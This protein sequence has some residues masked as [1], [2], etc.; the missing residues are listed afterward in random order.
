M[1]WGLLPEAPQSQVCPV[2]SQ[3]RHTVGR[4]HASVEGSARWSHSPVAAVSGVEWDGG[5]WVW[6]HRCGFKSRPDLCPWGPGEH[7]PLQP[8]SFGPRLGGGLLTWEATSWQHLVPC[9]LGLAFEASRRLSDSVTPLPGA[10]G[11]LSSSP[12]W[13]LL[14]A[15][16]C[17]STLRDRSWPGQGWREATEGR[18]DRAGP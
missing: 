3:G 9:C 13:G 8:Q 1:V 18:P 10:A 11:S 2:P 17:L 7:F 4:F 12:I 14:L 6:S 5:V 15:P 16:P